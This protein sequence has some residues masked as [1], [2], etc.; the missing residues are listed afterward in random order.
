MAFFYTSKLPDSSKFQLCFCFSDIQAN[1]VYLVKSSSNLSYVPSKYHKFTEVFSKSK[2]EVFT[3]HHPYNL[4]INLEGVQPLVGTIYSLLASEKETLKEFI[5]KISIQISS[6][7]LLLYIIFW[8]F[9]L[10][11]IFMI[12]S[13]T[14]TTCLYTTSMLKKYSN[15]STKLASIPK[16]R[17]TS[18]IP[19]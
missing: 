10:W 17:D 12:Y 16:Q 4:K 9:V 3:P 6:N 2:T 1:F 13:S 7:L 18:F 5:K 11:S 14:L 15:I 19:S 8:M